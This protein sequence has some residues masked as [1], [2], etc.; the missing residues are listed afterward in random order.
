M[1]DGLPR[2]HP[3]SGYPQEASGGEAVEVLEGDAGPEEVFGAVEGL[4][5]VVGG[6]DDP[7]AVALLDAALST[8]D[9]LGGGSREPVAGVVDLGREGG[10]P[11]RVTAL[12]GVGRGFLRRSRMWPV[13]LCRA[14]SRVSCAL[15]SPVTLA[16]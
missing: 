13:L 16:R 1:R 3:R 9:L 15:E 2:R 5:L 14:M 11:G 8:E 4:E 7:L 10:V 12:E 6:G